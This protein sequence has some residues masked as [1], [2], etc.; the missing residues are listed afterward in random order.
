MTFHRAFDM[1][2][3][4]GGIDSLVNDIIDLGFKRILTS[5]QRKSALDGTDLI[6]KLQEDYGDRIIIMPGAGIN[7]N[8]LGEIL[9]ATG[10]Q[11]FHGSA[12]I[13]VQS[14]MKFKNDLFVGSS[15]YETMETAIEKVEKMVN[16]FANK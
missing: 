3:S 5:G 13:R 11:E 16:I 6:K 2:R 12:R 9:R 7:E 10:V 15:E 14:R 8:N 4:D 1:A